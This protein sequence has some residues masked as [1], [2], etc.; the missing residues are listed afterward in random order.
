MSV[1]V[2]NS[3]DPLANTAELEG[4]VS[5]PA[6]GWTLNQIIN[7]LNR[8]NSSWGS[9]A[10]VTFSFTT[11]LPNYYGP[12]DSETGGYSSFAP[13]QANAARFALSLWD[14]IGLITFTEVGANSGT[15]RFSNSSSIHPD[16]S[17]HAYYAHPTDPKGGDVWVNSSLASN[18]N[19]LIGNFAF[20]TLVH[21]IGHA[22]GQPHPGDYNAGEG[23][24]TYADAA[25]VQDTKMYSIMSYWGESNTGGDFNGN[26]PQTPMLHDI[27][28]F[29]AKYGANMATRN[30]DTTYGF[31]ASGTGGNPIYDFTQ[32]AGPVFCIW[33]GGGNDTIDLS[34]SNS[35]QR[36]TLISGQ[37]SS[38]AQM[39]NN[40]SIA[41]GA[42]IENAIT[43][44]GNDTLTG[45]GVANVLDAGL[46]NDNVTGHGGNDTMFGRGGN[47]TLDGGDGE[48]KIFGGPGWDTMNGG[49]QNDLILASSG[50]DTINGGTGSDNLVGELGDDTIRGG[51]GNDTING[52]AG[53]DNLYGDDGNDNLDGGPGSDFMWGG[54]GNDFMQGAGGFDQMWG[55]DGSDRMFGAELNDRVYGQDGN[56]TVRGGTGDDY[57]HGGNDNDWVFGDQGNDQLFGSNGNDLVFG[58][59]GDDFMAG[60]PGNDT[61]NGWVG[62]DTCVGGTGADRFVWN[63]GDGTDTI[64]DYSF[65]GGDLLDV[66]G[67]PGSYTY[68]Q[69]GGDVQVRDGSSNLVFII[70]NYTLSDGL[71]LV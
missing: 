49:N 26:E 37:F 27:A 35:N 40:I 67:A 34:L 30:T 66:G 52:G 56:D 13:Q 19:P 44:G 60:G 4:P 2:T 68:A 23:N 64:T 53:T 48:D 9:G 22:L 7:Q 42:T 47:D 41:Y 58:Q 65:A 18:F 24:P 20:E 16:S 50:N 71:A 21:E 11:V 59:W 28:A 14:D 38:I 70:Q 51:V 32:N 10:N 15:I 54:N 6:G 8:I 61:L 33:D 63:N 39:I 29:Q 31:N 57:V 55:G 12:G 43:G 3:G 25:Y 1:E 5:A 36:L 69:V 46:G 62:D 17:A 45:N